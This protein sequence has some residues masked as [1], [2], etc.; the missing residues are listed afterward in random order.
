MR[1]QRIGS[2]AAGGGRARGTQRGEDRSVILRSRWLVAGWLRSGWRGCCSASIL[3]KRSIGQRGDGRRAACKRAPR[4]WA[5]VSTSVEN[6][7]GSNLSKQEE[8]NEVRAIGNR[9]M[10][11][12]DGPFASRL[13]RRARRSSDSGCRPKFVRRV[14]STRQV[15]ELLT[16]EA[17]KEFLI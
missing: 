14:K 8:W 10:R 7:S 6:R 5:V 3:P 16:G 4:I 15:N 1:M 9:S 11:N 17:G 12:G 13:G 2:A